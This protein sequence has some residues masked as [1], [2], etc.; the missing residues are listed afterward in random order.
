MSQDFIASLLEFP[1]EK[2]LSNKEYDKRANDLIKHL[3][4]Q[5]D[6][7]WVKHLNKGSI[8]DLLNPSTNSLPYLYA[9]V[10]QANNAGKDRARRDEVLNRSAVFFATFDPIQVRYAGSVFYD[11]L[12]WAFDAYPSLE[13]TD[14]S[15]LTTALLRLDPT[16]ATFTSS[17]LRLVR[18]CLHQGV[19][20]QALPILDKNI[21]AYPQTPPKNLPE[22]YICDDH[23]HSNAF[24]TLKSGFTLH[25][26]KPEWLLEY[27][28]LGA[29]VYLGQ[30]N[31]PRARL[32][33]EYLLL[34]PTSGAAAS[35]LQTEAYKKWLLLGLLAQGKA[36]PLPH[37]HSQQVMKSVKAVSRPYEALVEDFEKRAWRKFQAEADVG[38]GIWQEDG[39]TSLVREA[40]DALLRYRVLDLQNTYAA[41]PV[42]RVA[43]HLELPPDYV[44]NLLG[45]MLNQNYLSAHLT[46][47][48]SDP[49][50]HFH[51]SSTSTSPEVNDSDSLEARSNRITS[52]I[53]AI[54][55]ADRRLQLT[56]EYMDVQKRGKRGGAGP[57]GDLA[58][59]MDLTY[60]PPI[61][62]L[63]EDEEGEGVF[64]V[65][66]SGGWQGTGEEDIMER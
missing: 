13:I 46:T 48:T 59:Q 19:P 56:K 45:S 22:D 43:A 2:K 44:L 3:N 24:L 61:G 4:K 33:L 52:L 63:G 57:D 34:H 55:D 25:P 49:V 37:T 1:P 58:D 11:L 23:A 40:M 50:L 20:S 54:R 7:A 62:G 36:Y 53:A 9:L 16:G 6:S 51:G 8:L 26:L 27:Y 64:G 65:G 28:L 47:T 38:Q 18:L 14:C 32:F 41:L 42:S 15:P 17:H 12:T 30:R 21:T 35:G 10:A 60:D 29:H 39:N 5:S 31:F 66:G